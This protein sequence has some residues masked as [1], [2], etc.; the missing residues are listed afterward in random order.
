[1]PR[2]ESNPR[3]LAWRSD[4]DG[5]ATLQTIVDK[6]G[7]FSAQAAEVYMQAMKEQ[8]SYHRDVY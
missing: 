7:G 2:P 8:H 4:K 1:M 3:R 5:D 6:Q